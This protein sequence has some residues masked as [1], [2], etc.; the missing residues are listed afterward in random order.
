MNFTPLTDEQRRSFDQDGYLIVRNA[1]NAESV[2]RLVAA[3]DRLMDGFEFEGFYAHRR[4]GLVQRGLVDV[5]GRRGET[6]PYWGSPRQDLRRE[7]HSVIPETAG[8]VG[9]GPEK[10]RGM[11]KI[12][13]IKVLPCC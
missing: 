1:L 11:G 10:A 4:D 9:I 6:S 13:I 3:G 2:A 7:E 5:P 12:I 8:G